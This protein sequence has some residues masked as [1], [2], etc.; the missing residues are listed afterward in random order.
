MIHSIYRGT[1]NSEPRRIL[2]VMLPG[3]GMAADELVAHGFV[4]AVHDRRLPVDIV[5]AQPE[6]DAYLEGR[7]ARTLHDTVIAPAMARGYRRLWILGI[8]IGGIGALLYTAAR[9]A[10]VDGLVLLAPFLGTPGTLAEVSSAGGIPAWSPQNSRAT[11]VERKMLLWLQTFLKGS[12][13][14]PALYL[15]YGRHDRFAM[16]HGLLARPLPQS[17]VIVAEGGHD[18]ATWT[19]LWPQILERDPFTAEIDSEC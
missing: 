14:R 5:A 12:A 11:A 2:L 6:L 9:I 7:I 1:P 19:A 16:G 18:W 8:S 15:G 13:K 10:V 3:M 4:S 17:Q